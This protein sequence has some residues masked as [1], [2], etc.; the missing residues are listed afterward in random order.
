MLW[1]WEFCWILSAFHA[2]ICPVICVCGVCLWVCVCVC[3]CVCGVCVCVYVWCVCLCVC[4]CWSPHPPPPSIV[5]YH[6]QCM[7]I[8]S[9]ELCLLVHLLKRWLSEAFY[10]YPKEYS[11]IQDSVFWHACR[12][13]WVVRSVTSVGRDTSTWTGTTRRAAQSVSVSASPLFAEALTGGW[14]R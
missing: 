14:R 1:K 12:W 7:W 8:N 11:Q 6:T 9:F 10:D 3:V 2:N 5:L 13:M 4:V